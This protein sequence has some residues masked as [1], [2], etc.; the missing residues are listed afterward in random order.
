MGGNAAKAG[1]FSGGGYP[2]FWRRNPK[3]VGGN[4]D[5]PVNYRRKTVFFSGKGRNHRGGQSILRAERLFPGDC[6]RRGQPDFHW[7]AIGKQRG[8]ESPWPPPH[9]ETGGGNGGSCP[10]CGNFQSLAGSD[11]G[12]TGT[13]AGKCPSVCGVLPGVGRSSCIR[14]PPQGGRGHPVLEPAG[15][16]GASR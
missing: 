5:C 9:G 15:Y 4:P 12:H 2:V 10:E 11:A 14:L 1:A 7:P 3:P 6:R 16:A 8:T 13:D